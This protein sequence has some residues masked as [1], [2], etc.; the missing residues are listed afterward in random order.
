MDQA[1]LDP[2]SGRQLH[3][4]LNLRQLLL[5]LARLVL[6]LLSLLHRW[7]LPP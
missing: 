5:P 1:P 3:L 7:A 6:L 2:H 4:A